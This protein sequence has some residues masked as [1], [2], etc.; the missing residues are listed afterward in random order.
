MRPAGRC[1]S[2]SDPA[3][4]LHSRQPLQ[5][6]CESC[7]RRDS[8]HTRGEAWA[9]TNI[10]ASVIQSLHVAGCTDDEI[11]TLVDS[12]LEHND[13]DSAVTEW[14]IGGFESDHRFIRLTG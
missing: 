8:H 4:H 12:V 9:S 6:L 13:P 5:P 11:R 3:T 10:L 7:A 14:Q 1:H 2:C